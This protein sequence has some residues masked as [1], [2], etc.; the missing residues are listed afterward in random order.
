MFFYYKKKW[1]F[2]S[3][4]LLSELAIAGF[5]FVAC[6]SLHFTCPLVVTKDERGV[7]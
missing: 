7:P 5:T 6:V 1:G 4:L 3:V 2:A